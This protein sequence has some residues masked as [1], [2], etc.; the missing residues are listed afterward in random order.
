MNPF[1]YMSDKT[2]Q[3][4]AQLAMT[5]RD[6]M[7]AAAQRMRSEEQQ[8]KIDRAFDELRRQSTRTEKGRV[9]LLRTRDG[10]LADQSGRRGRKEARYKPTRLGMKLIDLGYYQLVEHPGQ[11][12][13]E[14]RAADAQQPRSIR[15]QIRAER[16]R[17]AELT[18]QQRRE[19]KRGAATA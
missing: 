11:N 2:R 1:T 13:H 7:E 15:F 8:L 5:V 16:R 18:R 12:R 14:R 6:S 4:L 17:Q 3:A 9:P 10:K 19:L